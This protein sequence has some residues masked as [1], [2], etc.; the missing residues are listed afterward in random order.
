MHLRVAMPWP[1]TDP[2]PTS[3]AAAPQPS[4]SAFSYAEHDA[5]LGQAAE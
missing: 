1:T 2:L 3:G 5:Q 4:D